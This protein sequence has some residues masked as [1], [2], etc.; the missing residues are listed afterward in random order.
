MCDA[1]KSVE[2]TFLSQR[3]LYLA[4]YYAEHGDK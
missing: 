3:V 1:A 2:N 4:L